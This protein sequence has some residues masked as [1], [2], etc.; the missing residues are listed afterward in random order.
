PVLL[1]QLPQ[2]RKA[3]AMARDN[4]YAP[5]SRFTVGAAML[6]ANGKIYVGCNVENGAF[7][8]SL[9]AE[10]G[11]VAAALADGQRNF[12][13][14]AVLG[15]GVDIPAAQLPLCYPCGVCRQVL[16]EFCGEDFPVL[17]M[18]GVEADRLYTLGQL[19]PYGFKL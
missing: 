6:A 13:L 18:A 15:G 9:C 16:S 1:A 10:R 7:A 11:A 3:A 2:L 14:L 5:Y 8:P 19:L 4:A 12:L 17:V